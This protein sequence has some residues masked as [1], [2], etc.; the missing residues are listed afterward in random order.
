[1]KYINVLASYK[2]SFIRKNTINQF[3][4]SDKPQVT[5]SNN[6]HIR[7]DVAPIP[8]GATKSISLAEKAKQT[9]AIETVRKEG[10]DLFLENNTVVSTN[11]GERL[12]QT[13]D[14]YGQNLAIED[15]I[16][17]LTS[18][19]LTLRINAI[20]EG[21]HSQSTCME[22]KSGVLADLLDETSDNN[23]EKNTSL[24]IPNNSEKGSMYV[25]VKEIKGKH[26][27]N[28][29]DYKVNTTEDDRL[30]VK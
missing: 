14:L 12:Y 15:L 22:L 20:R 18:S 10:K 11:A 4:E 3:E 9:E 5:S 27:I 6:L 1:M 8:L 16:P 2:M 7:I 30:H 13:K 17:M 23:S 26:Y 19:D 28:K 25:T 24:E 29:V 21:T